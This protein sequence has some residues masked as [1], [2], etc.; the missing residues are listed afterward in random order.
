MYV[1]VSTRI[2]MYTH[3]CIGDLRGDRSSFLYIYT[4]VHYLHVYV[5]VVYAY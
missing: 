1:Y 4:S 2:Y 3:I 5:Y